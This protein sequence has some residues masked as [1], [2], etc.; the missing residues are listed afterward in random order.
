MLTIREC[1]VNR[2]YT[3]YVLVKFLQPYQQISK[4]VQC[5]MLMLKTPTILNSLTYFSEHFCPYL[6]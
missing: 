5:L 1:Q 4:A 6:I 3:V 2:L